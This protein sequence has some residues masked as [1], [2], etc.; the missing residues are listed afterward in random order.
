MKFIRTDISGYP[1]YVVLR[2]DGKNESTVLGW[3][4]KDALGDGWWSY[5]E[6]P[7]VAGNNATRHL[8][9][10]RGE[11]AEYLAGGIWSEK[12]VRS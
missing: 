12:R 11:A 2:S 9:G 8:F 6:V 10:T 1:F 3:V 7:T 4:E 5:K